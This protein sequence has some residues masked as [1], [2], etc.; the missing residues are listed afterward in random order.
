MQQGMQGLTGVII[1]AVVGL[2]LGVGL[3][4]VVFGSQMSPLGVRVATETEEER[5][6]A[7]DNTSDIKEAL[8]SEW[9]VVLGEQNDSGEAGVATLSDIGDGTTKVLM[10][11]AAAPGATVSAHPAH[12]HM[13]SCPKPGAIKYNLNDVVGGKSETV[14]KATVADIKAVLP[15][16]INVHESSSRINEYIACG[17]IKD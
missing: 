1:G 9:Q 15:V 2:I 11:M 7:A 16:A 8:G 17:D 4:Y 14:I 5:Q 13:G 3:G 10:V 12:I 6:A